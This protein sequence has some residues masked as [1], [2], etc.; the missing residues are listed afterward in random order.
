MLLLIKRSFKSSLIVLTSFLIGIIFCELILRVKHHFVINYDI[1]MWKYAKEL[2]QKVSNIKINHIHI[3][4]KSAKLQKTEIRINNQGQ[5][6]INYDNSYLN[7]FDRSFLVLGSSVVLGWGVDNEK[8]FTNVMNKKAIIEGK[9]WIFINGGVGNYNTE[10]YINNYF[11]NWKS[12]EFSDVIIHFFVND[13]ELIK[14]AETNYFTRNFHLGVVLWKLFNSYISAFSPENIKDYYKDRYKDDYEG[15]IVA[16]KELNKFNTH[17]KQK[18]INC[19]FVL[20]PDIHKLEPYNLDFINKKMSIIS[21]KL[22]LP[23][24]DLLSTFEGIDS[25]KIWNNYNDPHPNDYAHSLMG[26][27]IFN[28]ISK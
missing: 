26:N 5:R 14:A 15:F 23:L 13:T 28:F 10:R 9:K 12:L 17:C 7:K 19:H 2:K 1:E 21:Q 11:E 4:N 27:A 18:K 24:L 20:M 16:K 6:D 25:K 3:P 22:N 8:T